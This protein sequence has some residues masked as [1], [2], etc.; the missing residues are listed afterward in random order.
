M[1]MK[2]SVFLLVLFLSCK[3]QDF[4]TILPGIDTGD[5]SLTVN[6]SAVT[7]PSGNLVLE[8]TFEEESGFKKWNREVCR[9]DAIKRSYAVARKGYSSARFEFKKTDVTTYRGY[10]RAEL[11]Q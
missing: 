1:L 3:K 11:R 6:A 5:H 10:V 8:S 2:Y 4:A 7:A 9:E